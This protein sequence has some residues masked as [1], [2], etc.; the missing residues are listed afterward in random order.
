ML[1]MSTTPNAKLLQAVGQLEGTNATI[2]SVCQFKRFI[3]MKM[4]PAD[5]SQAKV[6]L[7]F[8]TLPTKCSVICFAIE[9]V[10]ALAFGTYSHAYLIHSS[11]AYL[12]LELLPPCS[13]WEELKDRLRQMAGNIHL[14]MCNVF[15][16]C[17]RTVMMTSPYLLLI[18][19]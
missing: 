15:V 6:D 2:H 13:Q 11:L 1:A 9:D 17:V 10:G 5:Q 18:M 12:I 4:A 19:I 8:I 7:R 3:V 16:V 14:D